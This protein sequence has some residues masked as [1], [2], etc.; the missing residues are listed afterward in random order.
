MSEQSLGQYRVGKDFNPSGNA[1]VDNLKE[2]AARFIDSCERYRTPPPDLSTVAAV[3]RSEL[4]S[5]AQRYAEIA[6]ML[7][8]KAVTKRDRE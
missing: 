3:E 2:D 5:L 4:M 7:A 1:A 8:V 6:A